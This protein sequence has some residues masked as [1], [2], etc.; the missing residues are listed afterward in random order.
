[1]N[2]VAFDLET[3]GFMVGSDQIVEI[4]AVRFSNGHPT[5]AFATLINPNRSIPPEASRVSGITDEMLV[6]KPSIDVVMEPFAE[7][8]RDDIMVA[9]NAPFDFQFVLHDVKRLESAAPRG[10]V[11]DTCALARKVF[12]GLINYKLGTLV[13][14]LKFPTGVFHRAQEDATYCGQLFSE[15]LKKLTQNGQPPAIETLINLQGGKPLKF[16]VIERQP[17]QLDLLSL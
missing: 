8:C 9:H 1:M 15:T 17:K 16:P 10:L 3:T 4:A 2:F 11:L 6:G 12:P 5:E 14:H 7:F 13:Q